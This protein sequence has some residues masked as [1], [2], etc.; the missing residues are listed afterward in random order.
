M[1]DLDI[2]SFFPHPNPRDEQI[3]ILR[4]VEAKWDRLDV[5]AIIAP[6]AFGKTAIMSTI[7]RWWNAMSGRGATIVAPN[8]LLATQL[9]ES[10]GFLTVS[11][12]SNYRF[13]HD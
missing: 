1:E 10:T 13:A 11:N 2:M 4:E 7:G 8:R 6:T 12:K 5:I 3:R 9:A